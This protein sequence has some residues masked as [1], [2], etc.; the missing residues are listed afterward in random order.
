MVSSFIVNTYSI[1]LID[2]IDFYYT[3]FIISHS[4][5]FAASM[6]INV[7]FSSV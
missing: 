6:S 5:I 4:A 2:F 3:L 1:V 7:Q